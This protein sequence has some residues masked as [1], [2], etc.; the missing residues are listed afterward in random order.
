MDV[1]EFI[2]L[3]ID[4]NHQIYWAG[5]TG[6]QL[7][8]TFQV[9]TIGLA[10]RIRRA[11]PWPRTK[12]EWIN[13]MHAL[14]WTLPT[15][16]KICEQGETKHPVPHFV[17]PVVPA[18]LRTLTTDTWE[19]QTIS[20]YLQKKIDHAN[21]FFEFAQQIPLCWPSFRYQA[22][23][24]SIAEYQNI[25]AFSIFVDPLVLPSVVLSYG[26]A[27]QESLR[28]LHPSFSVYQKHIE[29]GAFFEFKETTHECPTMETPE[30]M[31]QM[32]TTK[33]YEEQ[34]FKMLQLWKLYI[35]FSNASSE[36]LNA[37]TFWD[38]FEWTINASQTKIRP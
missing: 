18:S 26:S 17:I 36:L 24:L 14:E 12:Q 2:W 9:D 13:R 3:N 5:D 29:Q 38:N 20:R 27:L 33:Q 37:T 11:Q 15:Q 4:Q 8:S 25:S 10:Q 19:Y 30:E 34:A 6:I 22:I 23:E 35:R 28:Y 21:Q 31:P 7:G 32:N 16:S 1:E